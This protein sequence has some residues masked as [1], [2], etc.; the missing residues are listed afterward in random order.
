M[1]LSASPAAVLQQPRRAGAQAGQY[2]A[3]TDAG[4]MPEQTAQ[5]GQQLES[6]ER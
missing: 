1:S 6:A 5:H 4:A 2:T 3:R